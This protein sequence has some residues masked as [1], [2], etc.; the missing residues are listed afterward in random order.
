MGILN[1]VVV[2]L[3][4]AAEDS[5]IEVPVDE[6]VSHLKYKVFITLLMMYLNNVKYFNFYNLTCGN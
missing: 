1:T 6:M 5:Q 3:F 2:P 4:L